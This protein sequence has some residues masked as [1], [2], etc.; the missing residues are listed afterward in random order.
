MNGSGTTTPCTTSLR[1]TRPS[2]SAT[3]RLT[4]QYAPGDSPVVELLLT[5]ELPDGT[6]KSVPV[7]GYVDSGAAR[8]YFPLAIADR[9]G[10]RHL[11]TKNDD[12]SV[13]L[14]SEFDTWTCP[15]PIFGQIIAT[16]PEPQGR[17]ERGPRL[18]LHPWF[19][20]P[21]DF[22]LGRADFFQAFTITFVENPAAPLFHLDW[23]DG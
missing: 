13:G 19:G 6:S 12:P 10:I 3:P 16:Y 9:L 1:R 21:E 20:E 14:G 7:F 15:V 5:A 11:L 18:T 2:S 8:S 4:T 17:T 22:L 23:E